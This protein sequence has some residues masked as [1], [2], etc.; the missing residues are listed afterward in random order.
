VLGQTLGAALAPRSQWRSSAG[1]FVRTRGSLVALILLVVSFTAA[2]P[3]F[4]TIANIHSIADA[5]AIVAIVAVGQTFVILLGAIDLSVEGVMAL[6]AVATSLL[7]ANDR[8]GVN[9]G[10]FAI[11]AVLALGATMGVAAGVA[12]TRMRIPSF[13][14]TLGLWAIGIGL[15]TV[16]FGGRPPVIEHQNFLNIGL[17]HWLG[18]TKISYIALGVVLFAWFLQRYTRFGRYAYVIGGAEDVARLSGINVAKYKV[19][20]FTFSGT[21][22]ALASILAT[23]ELGVGDVRTGT[24]YLFSSITAVV[25]GGTLLSGGRG[26]V[27]QSMIGALIIAVIANGMVLVGISPLAQ[28]GVQGGIILIAVALTGWPAR[29]RLRV[30]K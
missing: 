11:P 8:N 5:A 22:F 29:R 20:I 21:M 9:L 26:G 15:G 23:S 27:V 2:N 19:L 30:I 13:M 25:V 7:V 6:S 1:E 4:L 14:A 12:N 24:G 17:G 28:Q 10:L 16:L 18:F 3:S